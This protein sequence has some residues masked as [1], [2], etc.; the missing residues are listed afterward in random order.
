MKRLTQESRKLVQYFPKVEQYWMIKMDVLRSQY[1]YATRKAFGI[2]ALS[3]NVLLMKRY[4]WVCLHFF[5]IFNTP[6]RRFE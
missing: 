3:K 4:I 6:N 1:R 5:L 2:V